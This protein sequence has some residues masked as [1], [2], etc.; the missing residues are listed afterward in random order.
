MSDETERQPEPRP[1][2]DAEAADTEGH[3]FA[4]PT[5]YLDLAREH[6]RDLARDTER[7]RSKNVESG[8]KKRR[9]PFG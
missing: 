7:T 1:A 8:K 2:D 9:W 3:S 4:N 6:H 5:I